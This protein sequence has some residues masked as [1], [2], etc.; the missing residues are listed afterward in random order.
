MTAIADAICAQL[1]GAPMVEY[2]RGRARVLRSPLSAGDRDQAAGALELAAEW[3]GAAE[4]MIA[5]QHR[6][7]A[8]LEALLAARVDGYDERS[9]TEIEDEVEQ[10]RRRAG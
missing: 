8:E 6:H 4:G 2:L 7:I 1:P 3:I 10:A 9:E 5:M